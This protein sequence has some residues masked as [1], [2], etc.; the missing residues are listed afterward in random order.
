MYVHGDWGLDRLQAAGGLGFRQA[1]S[2]DMG[3]L[4]VSKRKGLSTR[5]VF[6][7]T[8]FPHRP[9]SPL[10]P[11][12][13]H[14]S[15]TC[16]P[17][18]STGTH[19]QHQERLREPKRCTRIAWHAHAH[20]ATCAAAPAAAAAAGAAGP[21]EHIALDIL[22]VNLVEHL[23]RSCHLDR[24]E[25]ACALLGRQHI[26]IHSS[27]ELVHKRSSAHCGG[28]AAA[29]CWH[30]HARHVHRARHCAAWPC[31]HLLRLR[32]AL[33]TLRRSAGVR[34]V[35]RLLTRPSSSLA[36][37]ASVLQQHE[38][39]CYGHSMHGVSPCNR[40]H[41]PCACNDAPAQCI[42]FKA[43]SLHDCIR[44]A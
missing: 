29:R 10:H 33:A 27:V 30:T 32:A 38:A 26:H 12:P 36:R 14:I 11:A 9:A 41:I 25:C 42:P 24:A 7:A 2:C 5:H 39:C 8:C 43:S 44:L 15:T 31:R 40:E 19:L 13:S 17:H 23:L 21:R 6:V 28:A 22:V 35:H 37:F 16:S 4:Q 34:Q 18:T 1:S 3:P 20:A